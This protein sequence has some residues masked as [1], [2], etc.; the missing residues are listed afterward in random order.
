METRD[1]KLKYSHSGL[2]KHV[3]SSAPTGVKILK[4]SSEP[5]SYNVNKFRVEITE[6]K[7]PT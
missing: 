2:T 4:P 7:V 5:H 3:C 1:Y 6:T